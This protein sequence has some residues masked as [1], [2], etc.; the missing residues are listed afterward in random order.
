MPDSPQLLVILAIWSVLGVVAYFAI[1]H[2]LI[3]RLVRSRLQ[4]EWTS[5]ELESRL[6]A[7]FSRN[8]LTRW[9]YVSGFRAPSAT[10]GFLLL[11]FL[12]LLLG[13]GLAALILWSGVATLFAD[14]LQLIPGGV[15]EVFLPIAWVS[16]WFAGL[17]LTTL[18]TLYVRAARRK[19]I[20]QIEQDLP[21][22]LDLLA[23]LAEA[24]LSFDAALDRILEAQPPD[25][26]LA[27]D[28]RLFQVDIL[29]GRARIAALRRLMQRVDVPWFSIFIS[30]L[31]HAEEVGS[32]LASTLRTQADDLRMRRRE[33]ALAMA[34]AIPVKL[35]FPLIVCFLPGIMTA[36]LGPVI[37]QIV[38][39][40]DSFLRG[41]LG[42]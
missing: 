37:Y 31:M 20:Q 7:S 9:L 19:R 21:L 12:G 33:R 27:E 22:Q 23:T 17:L 24:G 6:E 4:S 1:R 34:M 29:A 15:G 39:V 2:W 25:R 28:F 10:G 11:S 16:P 3:R 36:A 42:Q 40:L 26:P 35:L 13:A 41:S 5:D 18:P 38:Q 14:L 8:F 32:S 30:A